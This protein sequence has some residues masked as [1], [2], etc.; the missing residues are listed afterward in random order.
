M[1]NVVTELKNSVE[2]FE[3]KL[4]YAE[5]RSSNLEDKTLK[6]SH[7]S[8]KKKQWRKSKGIRGHTEENNV[9]IME[10][11]EEDEKEKGWK[12]YLKQ[13]WL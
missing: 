13:Y 4:N 9:S 8:K 3:S 1:K 10:I 7:Q 12:V 5:E 6:I 11:L 2:I